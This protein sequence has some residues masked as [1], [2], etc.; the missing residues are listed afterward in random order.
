MTSTSPR[1]FTLIELLVVISVVGVLVALLL[2]ALAGARTASRV[3]ANLSNQRQLQI[4]LHNYAGDHRGS[5]PFQRYYTYHPVFPDSVPFWA[6]RL[7]QWRYASD[8]RVFWGPFR[9]A[10]WFGSPGWDS[11]AAMKLNYR[12]N[13]YQRTGYG[14]NGYLM[15]NQATAGARPRRVDEPLPTH[16]DAGGVRPI[17]SRV[18]TLAECALFDGEDGVRYGWWIAGDPSIRMFTVQGATASG[19][20]DGHAAATPVADLNWTSFDMVRGTWTP[21]SIV[22]M[23][24]APWF[25]PN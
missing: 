23:R 24:R 13:N 14:V 1:G 20:L 3:A 2:P 12:S 7:L 18:L 22:A 4:A 17:P 9:D 19:Y 11:E 16:S 6:G 5:L 8:W 25:R 10:S 21:S 15:P